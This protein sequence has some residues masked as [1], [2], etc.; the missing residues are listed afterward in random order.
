VGF[1]SILIESHIARL[2]GVGAALKCNGYALTAFQLSRIA[3]GLGQDAFDWKVW[4]VAAWGAT[5]HDPELWSG[6]T[7]CS[8]RVQGPVN[9]RRRWIARRSSDCRGI[10]LCAIP[11][12]TI[13]IQDIEWN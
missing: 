13:D 5:P 3:L 6:N 11:G 10:T 9:I 8:S 4:S 7:G 1:D 2:H 12:R